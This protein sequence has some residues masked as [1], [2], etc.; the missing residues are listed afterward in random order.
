M[1]LKGQYYV[2]QCSTFK[3][4]CIGRLVLFNRC[5]VY[6]KDKKRA[7]MYKNVQKRALKVFLGPIQKRASSRS[8]QLEAVRFKALLYHQI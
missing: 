4:L 1:L 6:L 8:V 2:L 3:N 7:S 5:F